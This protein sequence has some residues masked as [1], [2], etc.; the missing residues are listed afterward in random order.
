[1]R[2]ALKPFDLTHVQ[3]VLLAVATT[4]CERGGPVNQTQVVD[5]ADVDK[6]M[7]SQVLRTLEQKGLLTR[8]P[9]PEDAR[10]MLIGVTEQ[11]YEAAA[12][13]I[14]SVEAA[15]E[16]FF[17]PLGDNAKTLAGLLTILV[18]EQTVMRDK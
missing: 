10:A 9:D 17:R 8:R 7:G 4:L 12:T 14:K 5:A 18:A 1:M 15:D 11:G 3:F 2:S 13:A 16:S 6:M